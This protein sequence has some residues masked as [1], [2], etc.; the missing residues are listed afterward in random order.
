MTKVEELVTFKLS[1]A[2]TSHPKV[3]SIVFEGGI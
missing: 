1:I 3:G 2:T